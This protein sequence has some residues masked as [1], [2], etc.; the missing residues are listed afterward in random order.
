[1][2]LWEGRER[3]EGVLAGEV[4]LS[5]NLCWLLLPLSWP[6]PFLFVRWPV[7]R[8]A[9]GFGSCPIQIGEW[10]AGAFCPP[11]REKNRFV[12][13]STLLLWKEG[14]TWLPRLC[15][16]SST[17]RPGK[18]SRHPA[19]LAKVQLYI[20]QSTWFRFGGAG[21]GGEGAEARKESKEHGGF[22]ELSPQICKYY[23]PDKFK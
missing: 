9:S 6:F 22:G 1:M 18:E 2:N 11:C 21:A 14:C 17:P 12:G 3:K 16:F 20:V 23:I 19:H 4:P 5:G 13:Y 15:F 7:L 10:S 8:E